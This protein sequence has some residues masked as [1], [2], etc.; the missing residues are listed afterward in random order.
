[1]KAWQIELEQRLSADD[2]PPVLTRD[3]LER[4]ARTARQAVE[5]RDVPPSTLTYWLKQ[6]AQRNRLILVK[7]GLYLNRFRAIPGQPADAT[8]WLYRDSVVSLNTVLGDAGVLNNPTHVITAVVPIDRGYPPP[9]L[10]RQRTRAGTFHFFGLPRRVLDAGA[11]EDRLEPQDA[12]EHPRA[13]P[14]KALVDWLYLGHSPR[15]RRTLPPR[16]D[17]DLSML[18]PKQLKNLADAAGIADILISWR[19]RNAAGA[20]RGKLRVGRKLTRDEMNER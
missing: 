6:A 8:P 12:Y 4:F 17:L 1:M 18:N 9:R 2:A 11:P 13:T 10:G 20:L 5:G 7:S 15:S 3:L 19:Y 14:E 16:G